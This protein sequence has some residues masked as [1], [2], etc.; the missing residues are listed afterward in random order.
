M[1]ELPQPT[2]WPAALAVGLVAVAFGLITVGIFFYV[3]VALVALAA[4]GWIRELLAE[5]PPRHSE[6][7]TRNSGPADA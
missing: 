4:S 3:G 2:I 5:P 1:E 6:L 7:G